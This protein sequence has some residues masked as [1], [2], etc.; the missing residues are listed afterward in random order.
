LKLKFV[1]NRLQPWKFKYCFSRSLHPH[2]PSLSLLFSLGSHRDAE[3]AA[4]AI[5][6]QLII[7]LHDCSED[8]VSQRLLNKLT[9]NGAEKLERCAEL[10]AKY[11]KALLA[12]EKQ[13]ESTAEALKVLLDYF[14]FGLNMQIVID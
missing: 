4:I 9:E 14:F 8:N 1:E 5:I 6:S 7:R 11:A 10:C 12:T 2:L 13:I 3:E